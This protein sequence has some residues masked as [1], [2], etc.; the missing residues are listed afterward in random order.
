MLKTAAIAGEAALVLQ[1]VK[2]IGVQREVV[3]LNQA[4]LSTRMRVDIKSACT[5]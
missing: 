4:R 5:L 1:V 2:V 3:L